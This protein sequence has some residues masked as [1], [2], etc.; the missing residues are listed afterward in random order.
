[1]NEYDKKMFDL[2]R[3]KFRGADMDK[4]DVCINCA[5]NPCIC[6]ELNENKEK[7]LALPD[8][9]ASKDDRGI[10]IHKVGVT[11]LVLPIYV[12]SKI[13]VLDNLL[14]DTQGTTG[15][16]KVTVE[17]PKK[18]KGTHM[19]RL[20]RVI[21]SK[22]IKPISMET[23]R[24]I[25]EEIT[26]IDELNA[27]KG[28]IELD[29]TYYIWM[30]APDTGMVAPIPVDVAFVVSDYHADRL[31]VETPVMSVCPCSMEMCDGKS[32]N[33][34]C[35]VTIEVETNDWVWIEDLVNMAQCS[36]SSPVYTVLRRTD[37]KAVVESAHKKPCFVEDVIRNVKVLLDHDK[38][39]DWYRVEVE[40]HES[41]HAHNAY[42]EL[43]SEKDQTDL[44]FYKA[45][46]NDAQDIIKKLKDKV[47]DESDKGAPAAQE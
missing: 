5:R 29:F 9:Q 35:I 38:R 23:L 10:L 39:I 7:V 25:L 3:G 15:S 47:K 19:S 18:Q 28:H 34:N 43:E 31:I 36:G 44:E 42:A 4:Q 33:Q 13:E 41:I 22:I 26:D 2:D 37:E 14:V 20:V 27:S 16:F 17:V 32:H 30:K 24:E 21:N 8:V 12:K 6:K 11:E 45:S 1:M 40:S 46:Y